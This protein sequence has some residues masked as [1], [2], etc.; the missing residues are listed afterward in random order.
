[1]NIAIVGYGKM[2][3]RI[4]ALSEELDVEIVQILDEDNNQNGSGITTDAFDNV[5][6]AIDFSHPS[7]VV[8]NIRKVLGTGTPVVVGTTGWTQEMTNIRQFCEERE[9]RLLYGSNF[10]I[11][12][13]LFAKLVRRAAE[14]YGKNPMFDAALHEVH[15]IQKADAPSGTA[16][17][18][19]KQWLKGADSQSTTIHK[20]IPEHGKI[21]PSGFYV[22]SQRLGGIFGEHQLRINSPFDDIEITHRALSRDAFASGALRAAEWLFHQKNPGF[23]LLEDIVEELG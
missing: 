10:S 9:G 3:Q 19:A 14:L 12:V 23:Y 18:L 20:G 1:M 8:T 13:Q 22:T 15:H 7:V 5:D 21:D 6:V 16:L 2:G 17:T 11:G 4:Q